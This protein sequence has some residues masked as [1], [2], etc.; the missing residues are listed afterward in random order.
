MTIEDEREDYSDTFCQYLGFDAD[1]KGRFGI[2]LLD[3]IGKR[4]G[5][6]LKSISLHESVCPFLLTSRSVLLK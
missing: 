3:S 6:S 1:P 4:T 2:A 5:N